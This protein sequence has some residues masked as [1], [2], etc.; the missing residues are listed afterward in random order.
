MFRLI[1]FATA[2]HKCCCGC[3]EQVNTP[4]TPTDWQLTFD[5]E[6]I[7]L[8]ASIGNWRLAC[9]SHYWI[10][11]N[12]V[13]WAPR[14]SKKEIEAGRARDRLA[15]EKYFDT[16]KTPTGSET[17]ASARRSKKRKSEEGVWRRLRRWCSNWL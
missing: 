1:P 16:A 15:K 4:L 9:E 7:S 13:E 8:Y 6:S 5:G 14:W 17:K 10:K 12:T 2:A 3:G 11:R